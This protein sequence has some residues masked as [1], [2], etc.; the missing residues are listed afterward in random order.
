MQD[1]IHTC[2]RSYHHIIIIIIIIIVLYNI[3]PETTAI[4]S[5]IATIARK[6]NEVGGDNKAVKNS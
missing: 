3:V 2:K 4:P 6:G 5:T 1:Y